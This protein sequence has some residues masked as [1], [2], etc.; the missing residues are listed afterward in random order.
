[1]QALSDW[2][3]GHQTISYGAYLYKTLKVLDDDVILM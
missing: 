2:H 1:M 3:L